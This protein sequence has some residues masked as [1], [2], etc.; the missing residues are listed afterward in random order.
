MQ[1]NYITNTNIRARVLVPIILAQ[2]FFVLIG[3]YSDYKIF[4]SQQA[5]QLEKNTAELQF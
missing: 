5:Q 4:S 2:T 3:I 1:G